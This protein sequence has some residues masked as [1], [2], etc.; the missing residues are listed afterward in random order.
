MACGWG[1]G[2]LKLLAPIGGEAALKAGEARGPASGPVL[3]SRGNPAGY[4]LPDIN[5]STVEEAAPHVVAAALQALAS[6]AAMRPLK[7]MPEP[8]P[9]APLTAGEAAG[10]GCR[11]SRSR[12]ALGTRS[13]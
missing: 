9:G 1:R 10:C 12:P 2:V 7:V 6:R 3:R 5:I 8:V 11:P 13:E 4:G